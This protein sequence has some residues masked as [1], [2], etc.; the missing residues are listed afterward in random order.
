MQDG[1][2]LFE[3]Y[4]KI[5]G[6]DYQASPKA[7]QKAF[8]R[9]AKELHPDK[10]PHD[11]AAA[12]RFKKVSEAY[13]T[14]SDPQKKNQY[15]LKL[16]YGAYASFITHAQYRAATARRR[17]T[18]SRFFYRRRRGFSRQARLWG[19]FSVIAIILVVAFTTIFLTSYNAQYDFQRGLT[20]YQNQ[21]YSSAYFNLKE[22]ISPFN[23]YLAA[24]HLLMAEICFSQQR[25]VTLI[26]AHIEKAYRASPSDSINARLL[27]LEGKVDYRQGHHQSAYQRF[28]DATTFLPE[29]DSATY[30]MGELDLFVFARFDRAL[31]HF[32][33]LAKNNPENHEALLAS[34][35]CHQKLEQHQKAITEIDKFLLTRRDVGMAHYIKAI[36]A[37]SLNLRE[38]SCANY[39]EAH[40]LNVPAALD[41]L[42][43]YCGMS[44]M[45]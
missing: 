16:R 34:A 26:K 27:Y 7:I 24:A 10:N 9:L 14:L 15:D 43:S 20:N 21:R 30:Q 25:N 22:S 18:V 1:I 17:R 29:F 31:V 33:T 37:Q 39:L 13:V 41:S 12:E 19:G 28:R 5:L 4:Y 45:R 3:D 8:H 11:L 40:R 42:N 44:L 35:Y 2:M 6:V 32:Q 36:S 38:I 23:P